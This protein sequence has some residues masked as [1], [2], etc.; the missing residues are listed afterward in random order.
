MTDNDDNVAT[1]SQKS[2][3]PFKAEYPF[4]VR[5]NECDRICQK[6]IDRIPVIVEKQ[7]LD[8]TSTSNESSN[9]VSKSNEVPA[10]DKRKY[11][12]PQSLTIGQFVYI[13]R[14]RID[15]PPERAIFV[16]VNNGILPNTSSLMSQL[17]LEYKD[18]DGF[19]Y[20]NYAG[21]NTFGQAVFEVSYKN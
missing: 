7:G 3:I 8:S 21:E 5:K 20:I 15:L 13:I 10:L 2:R 19:L 18:A 16:F 6:Y 11:L 14:K 9:N 4:N 12:V 1:L 17:Y